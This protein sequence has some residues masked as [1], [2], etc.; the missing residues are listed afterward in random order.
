[1]KVSALIAHCSL[2]LLLHLT[3]ALALHAHEPQQAD[4]NKP[5]RQTKITIGEETTHITGPLDEEGYVDYIAALNEIYSRG[6]TPENNAAVLFWRALGP[7]LLEPDQRGEFFKLLGM[8]PLPEE[9]NYWKPLSEFATEEQSKALEIA[10]L[11]LWSA[12]EFPFLVR[13]LDANQR[14]LD[15]IVQGTSRANYYAPII[16][17]PV[18]RGVARMRITSAPL[19]GLGELREVSRALVIRAMFR[20]DRGDL[21]G[22]WH[23]LMACHRLGRV[24]GNGATV[25]EDLMGIAIDFAACKGDAALAHF[26]KLSVEQS[27]QCQADLTALPPLPELAE[28]IDRVERFAFLEIVTD[29][30]RS[31]ATFADWFE[32]EDSSVVGRAMHRMVYSAID[33]DEILRQANSR[34]DLL[35]A[36]RR[37]ASKEERIAAM[38]QFEAELEQLDNNSVQK[39]SIAELMLQPREVLT[40]KMSG[41]LTALLMPALGSAFRAEEAAH[42]R[43]DLVQ[44]ALALG[45]YR[46]DHGQ[47]PASL[48]ALA[49]K[50]LVEVPKD[51]FTGAPLQYTTSGNQ[52]TVFSVGPDEEDSRGNDTHPHDDV[53]LHLPPREKSDE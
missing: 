10:A 25:I 53:V 14:P 21:D 8:E 43:V 35:V 36:C 48:K 41:M 24:V 23:D 4:G 42:T 52:A 1:M 47:Y 20:L 31:E 6:V 9:G 13:W 50:Y 30:S 49:P 12:S 38:R 17:Q 51:R 29:L 22:T 37:R 16:G 28:S 19:Y 7:N 26:G 15:L 32:G 18:E 46:T 34:Y 45:A 33:W 11:R 27:R 39:P 2:V 40:D 3:L 5:A 44:T